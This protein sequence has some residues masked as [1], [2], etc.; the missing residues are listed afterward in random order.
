MKSQRNLE[1]KEQ[2]WRFHSLTPAYTTK[3]QEL[4]LCGTDTKQTHGSMVQ[5]REH[6]S[7][8]MKV[9]YSMTK[10]TRIYNGG[11]TV[12]SINGAGETGQLHIIS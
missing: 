3:L 4:R 1:K 9:N 12:S 8:P 10:E 6:S 2:S 5:N 11:K 7:Q